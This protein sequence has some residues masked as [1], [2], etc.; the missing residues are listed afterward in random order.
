MNRL[1]RALSARA[2]EARRQAMLELVLGELGR[3]HVGEVLDAVRGTPWSDALRD[4][5][6][7]ELNRHARRHDAPDVDEEDESPGRDVR[8]R[9]GRLAL[10]TAV[11]DILRANPEGLGHAAI[12]ARAQ[13]TEAQVASSLRRL[14]E[15]G[16]AAVVGSA[17]TPIHVPR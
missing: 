3:C 1:S 13:A 7:A 16:R 15:R 10:D 17:E 8:S 2:A 11:L 5:T 14:V 4:L 9:A 6:V 12:E